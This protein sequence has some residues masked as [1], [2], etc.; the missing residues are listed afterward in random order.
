MNKIAV[1]SG[2][3]GTGKTTVAYS[4][5]ASL[6]K[7]GFKVGILDVDLTGPNLTDILGKNELDVV[8][9][10]FVPASAKDVRYVS[11]GQ[12]ASEGDPVLWTGKDLEA[13]ARQL[14]ERTDWGKL[15]YLVLD[16]PPGS[17]SESQAL[18]PLMDY[19]LIVTV[20]SVLAESNVRRIIEMCRETGTPIL[21]LIKNMTRFVCPGCGR[22]SVIFPE[23]HG[24]ED[25]GIPTIS[26]I[27]LN[28]KVAR[29]K[30]INDFPIGAVLEAMKTPVLLEKRKKSMKRILLELLFKRRENEG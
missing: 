19:A 18:L 21:G 3:G 10:R 7:R 8:N 27:P 29:E 11:L 9:D 6:A 22:E 20:P 30:L 25:L 13:A 14:L 5:A 12:I 24:F 16:F 15:D 1:I 4:L 23:D 2:K 28:P 26:E 17:G